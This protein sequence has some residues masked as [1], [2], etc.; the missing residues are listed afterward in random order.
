MSPNTLPEIVYILVY[1]AGTTEEAVYTSSLQNNQAGNAEV[2]WAFEEIDDCM[3]LS[4]MLVQHEPP[5]SFNMALGA[6][7]V[8]T[9]VPLSQMQQA[10][11]DMGVVLRLVP[12]P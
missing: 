11:Q 8:P 6:E 9:P 10:S 2:L 4:S 12:S 5:P 7:P 1:N 3:E